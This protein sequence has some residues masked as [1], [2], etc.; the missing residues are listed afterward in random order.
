MRTV[1]SAGV[2]V[3]VGFWRESTVQSVNV[4]ELC[5]LN[6]AVHPRGRHSGNKYKSSPI[7]KILFHGWVLQIIAQKTQ[8]LAIM[9]PIKCTKP[10]FDV[11]QFLFYRAL[12][13]MNHCSDHHKQG[14][15]MVSIEVICEEGMA[16]DRS[17]PRRRPE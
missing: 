13:L 11:S 5:G 6:V 15:K 3:T 12:S 7:L 16:K 1:S 9:Q 4:T 10:K 17:E 8:H 14:C 2:V